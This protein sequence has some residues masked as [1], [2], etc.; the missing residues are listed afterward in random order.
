MD[1]TCSD[2]ERTGTILH[3]SRPHLYR[4]NQSQTR[5]VTLLTLSD[6]WS[7][8]SLIHIA[9][10]HWDDQG[11][12]ARHESG[13]MLRRIVP[14]YARG[15]EADYYNWGNQDD[16]REE[17]SLAGLVVLLGD[18]SRCKLN[19]ALHGRTTYSHLVPSFGLYP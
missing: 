19:A 17:R 16:S 12:I 4:T 10:T 18:L 7:A 5:I 15:I 3:L 8:G 13:K 2:D 6:S 1:P 11:V 9:N 14:E